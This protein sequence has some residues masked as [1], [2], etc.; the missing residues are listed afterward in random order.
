M[1]IKIMLFWFLLFSGMV[2]SSLHAQMAG[3]PVGVRGQGEWTISALGMYMNQNLGSETAVSRR[4]FMK[5][6]WGLTPWLDFYLLGGAVQLEMKTG[7]EGV[8]D[9]KDK[10]R[11]AYGVGLNV[12]FK[13]AQN[14]SFWIW[15]G[16]H[17]IR[18]PS[19]GYFMEDI[20]IGAAAY[21]QK[22][23]MKYDWREIGGNLGIV[24][25]Y[26][27]FRFYAA[28]VGWFLQR[29]DTKRE[30]LENGNS[31]SFLGKQKGEY[32]SGLWTGGVVGLEINLPQRYS[33]S[34]EA[35]FFNE[36][37][38]QIMIG[39]CQTGGSAW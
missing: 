33:F 14:S 7:K 37:N 32:R 26:H 39:I 19:Y 28:G 11:F 1:K 30:Y 25:P 8:I 20:Y 15:G 22:F 6:N 34:V 35:L 5:S 17:G 18:F 3:N 4:I 9:Y 24:L 21:V 16:V 27:S 29:F 23:D 2:V 10:Y 38:Y 31:V 36:S 12:S 13:P